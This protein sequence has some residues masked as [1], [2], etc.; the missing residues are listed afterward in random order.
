[1]HST[2][3]RRC[4]GHAHAAARLLICCRSKAQRGF[5]RLRTQHSA[6]DRG[7]SW[8]ACSLPAWIIS[9]D[10]SRKPFP[11]REALPGPLTQSSVHFF[12]SFPAQQQLVLPWLS[13]IFHFLEHV[14]LEWAGE[15]HHQDLCHSLTAADPCHNNAFASQSEHETSDCPKDLGVVINPCLCVIFFSNTEQFNKQHNC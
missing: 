1:M 5:L 11:S 6:C 10:H 4:W 12:P 9:Q 7:C 2:A 15:E 8:A 13:I 3:S 14:G